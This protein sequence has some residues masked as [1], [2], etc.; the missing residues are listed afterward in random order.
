[1]AH[2]APGVPVSDPVPAHPAQQTR[3]QRSRFVWY[4]G[5]V[6][7]H[8]HRGRDRVGAEDMTPW[9]GLPP[10]PGATYYWRAEDIAATQGDHTDP[11]VMGQCWREGC[12]RYVP[13]EDDL[14]LC[15][16]CVEYLRTL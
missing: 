6:T 1:M 2:S 9:E 3:E 8:H 5:D 14:G 11:L 15:P 4:P 16:P 10:P 13:H 12:Y 7:I